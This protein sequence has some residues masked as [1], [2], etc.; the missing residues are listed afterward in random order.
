MEKEAPCKRDGVSQDCPIFGAGS[1][2]AISEWLMAPSNLSKDDP[3]TFLAFC[4]LVDMFAPENYLTLNFIIYS[5]VIKML[6]LY[7]L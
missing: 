3:A 5:T 7:N 2:R 1:G 6:Y 4:Y